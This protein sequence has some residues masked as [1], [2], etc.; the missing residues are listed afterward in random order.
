M[1][2]THKGL[3]R[4]FSGRGPRPHQDRGLS[5][6]PPFQP[7]PLNASVRRHLG[8]PTFPPS[9]LCYDHPGESYTSPTRVTGEFMW[10]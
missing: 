5:A 7:R 6:A 8:D 3:T 9:R 4:R 10:N 1:F 2:I